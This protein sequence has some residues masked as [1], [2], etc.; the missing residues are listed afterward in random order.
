MSESDVASGR[1]IRGVW[2][3]L[4]VTALLMFVVL[5][6]LLLYGES[7]DEHAVAAVGIK[8][9]GR[10]FEF[11]AG[12]ADETHL[13]GDR[14]V[15]VEANG[16][17]LLD[18]YGRERDYFL[19]DFRDPQVL[20]CGAAL[21]VADRLGHD[22][23]VLEPSG[24]FTGIT[25]TTNPVASH[26]RDGVLLVLGE[27]SRRRVIL[28]RY[29]LPEG[30]EIFELRPAEN[31]VVIKAALSPDNMYIDVLCYDSTSLGLKHVVRRYAADG[32]FL[33][34]FDV[35]D[36]TMYAGFVHVGSDIAVL[37]ADAV[38]R[39]SPEGE[40]TVYR[41]TNVRGLWNTDERLVALADGEDGAQ[42]LYLLG[43]NVE[44]IFR[45]SEPAKAMPSA[46]GGYVAAIDADNIILLDSAGGKPL[47]TF[48]INSSVRDVTVTK[49]GRLLV[50]TGNELLPFTL[51]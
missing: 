35:G 12:E 34:R 29:D 1:R 13:L 20:E 27:D 44:P 7:K 19:Y 5:M 9:A 26:Y 50:L 32:T 23:A 47:S 48:S 22:L 39:I 6:G 8:P 49:S 40:R 18:G 33:Q 3:Y 51:R 14:V 45:Y 16:I 21:V 42:F 38:V 25:G 30:R 2:I 36:D 37:G 4:G 31:E 17:L 10:G 15:R 43:Q 46:A 11:L 28:T 41:L 24:R